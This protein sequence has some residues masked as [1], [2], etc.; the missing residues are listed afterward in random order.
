MEKP[1]LIDALHIC[2]GG[3]LMILNHL[4]SNLIERK[5]NFY[6]LKDERCPKLVDED[7]IARLSSLS[8]DRRSRKTFYE[9]HRNEFSKVLCFGNIPPQI[10]LQIPVYTYIHNVSL[11]SIPKS[12]SFKKKWISRLKKAFIKHYGKYTDAW[13]VQTTNTEN[14]VKNNLARRWQPILQYPFFRIPD[15]M[16]YTPKDIRTDYCF[17]GN[18]TNAKGHDQLVNAW[19]ELAKKGFTPVLHLTVSIPWFIERINEACRQGAKIINHGVVPFNEV[20]E[21]Y[22]RSKALVYPSLNESL[23][24]GIIEAIEAGCDVIGAD[25]P[26]MH[27]VCSPSELFDPLDSQSIVDAVIHYESGPQ[28]PTVLKIKDEIDSFISFLNSNH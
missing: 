8:A 12:Y 25:L 7:K 19:I 6:L 22:N 10:K 16:N 1:I 9:Q 18:L 3:G 5:V 4:V 2:M 28:K 23:G 14:L 24:L 21:I 27:S 26:Y 17:I 11:L 13:I 15:G 20:I